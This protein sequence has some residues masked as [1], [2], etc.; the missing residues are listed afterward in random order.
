[1]VWP[2]YADL[3]ETYGTPDKNGDGLPD[4]DWYNENIVKIAPPYPM[5]WSWNKEPV[6]T[7]SIHTVCA[8]SLQRC[9]S[10]IAKN[11][12]ESEIK[13]Y[14]LNECG[15]GY[16]FRL[17]R[18]GRNLSVHSWGA[19]I[20]IAPSLNWLGRAYNPLK[21]MMPLLAVQIFNNEGWTWGGLWKRPD[22]MHFQACRQ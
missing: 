12:K 8:D 9:L 5:Y 21:G 3:N 10:G 20:D 19:A 15:G 1:M 14:R 13:K 6:R 7:I 16:N 4:I 18:G 11:F 2:L 22:A 17:M